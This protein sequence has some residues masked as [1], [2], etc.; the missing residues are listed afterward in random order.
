MTEHERLVLVGA[1]YQACRITGRLFAMNPFLAQQNFYS[2]QLRALALVE[3]INELDLA[4]GRRNVLIVGGGVAGRTLAAAFATIGAATTLLEAR[5]RPFER[6]RQAVHRELHPNI[7]FWPG[8]EP[9]PA[10]ALPFLNWA[11]APAKEVV[12]DLIAEWE[13][14]FGRKVRTMR[15]EVVEVREE[16]DRIKVRLKSGGEIEGDLCVFATGF[17]DER[18]LGNLRS[19]SYWSPGSV[20]DESRCV[21]VSGSGDGGLIDALSLILGVDVTRA[22][23]VLAISLGD[24]DLKEDVLAVE[25][26]RA[27]LS[28]AGSRDSEDPCTFYEGVRVP[29]DSVERLSSMSQSDERLEGRS[30]TLLHES[31]SAYSF[32]AAPIN[33]LLLAHFSNGAKPVV[34]TVKGSIKAEGGEHLVRRTDGES[35]SLDEGSRFDKLLLRHGADPGVAGIL[36][37]DQIQLLSVQA[38]DQAAAA[39]IQGYN[40]LLFAWRQN[41]MGK[42][43]VDLETQQKSLRRAVNQVGRAYG[44]DMRVNVVSS[45]GFEQAQPIGVELDAEDLAK[46]RSLKLFPLRVGAATLEPKRRQI[47]RNAPHDD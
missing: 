44:I 40:P 46:A 8:Q 31:A 12:E 21:L 4:R 6:Y 5:E 36:G 16:D 25:K 19:P 42:S 7:I 39:G 15:E 2:Q 18:T 14:G 20:A 22:A 32:T 1:V 13:A 43:A 23:H 3:A 9:V 24:S 35:E 45:A 33:K 26:K 11:Q 28:R 37:D 10:T 38:L 27:A 17:K 30:V 34:T 41:R 29:Q 47:H